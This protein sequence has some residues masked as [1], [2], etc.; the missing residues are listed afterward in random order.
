MNRWKRNLMILL[1]LSSLPAQPILL[2]E[3]ESFK[4]WGNAVPVGAPGL[5]KSGALCAHWTNSARGSSMGLIRTMDWSPYQALSFWMHASNALGT[6]FLLRAVS[7]NENKEGDYFHFG[8][9]NIAWSGW[10]RFVI[11][12]AAFNKSRNPKGWKAIQRF[13][14]INSGWGMKP[15]S[16]AVFHFDGVELLA[17][18]PK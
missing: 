11:P 2:D 7:T 17:S 15:D 9:S 13:D 1:V 5:A 10:R 14:F 18:L 16:N 8:P 4:G 3:I 12:L 6:R